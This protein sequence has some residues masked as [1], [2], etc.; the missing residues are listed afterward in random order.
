M[1][2][3]FNKIIIQLS[4]LIIIICSS[5]LIN[6]EIIEAV[7]AKVNNEIITLSEV[8][9]TEQDLLKT[10]SS[11]YSGEQLDKKIDELHKKIIDKM[12]EEILLSQKAKE[13]NIIVSDQE[14]QESIDKLKEENN[15]LTDE[16]LREALK[17]E[18]LTL[19]DL[20]NQIKNRIMQQKLIFYNL[21]GKISITE[22]ELQKYY[23]EHIKDF[24][25]PEKL[26]VSHILISFQQ[27]SKEEASEIA[28][29]VLNKLKSGE[30]FS[31]VAAKYSDSPTKDK[32]GDLGFLRKE[33]MNPSFSKEAFAMQIGQISDIIETE[34]GYHIFK[35]TDKVE[36]KVQPYENV[37][38]QI[39]QLIFSKR[40][41]KFQQEFIEKLKKE[42]YIEIIYNP[43][44]Q[45]H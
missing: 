19:E 3:Y 13:Q 8:K 28:Q 44:E 1:N 24:T 37:K 33:E 39:Y 20:K 15:I 34:E 45:Q 6:S 36:S 25:E 38:N 10:L 27:H 35:I 2:K 40:A 41:E 4:L 18:G 29:E 12:I 43:F 14:I 22:Q 17:Q 7:V 5:T 32:G 31:E 26:R 21:Q 42:S 11:L 23:K 16:Q 30:D 9:K